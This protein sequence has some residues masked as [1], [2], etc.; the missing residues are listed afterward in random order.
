MQNDKQHKELKALI[1]LLDEPDAEVYEQISSKIHAYGTD[2]IPVLEES[3]E[4]SFDPLLQERIEEIIHLIQLDD[5]YAELYSWAQ[6]GNDDLMRGFMLAARYQYPDLD[7]E[8]IIKQVGQLVQ[9]V[10]LELNTNLTALEKIKVVNHILFDVHKFRGNKSNIKS[11]DNLYL[12]ILL[13]TKKGNPLSIGILY[14]VI[15]RSL[16]LPVYGVDLPNHFVLAYMDV[17]E[18]MNLA[19]NESDDHAIFYVNPFNRGMLFTHNEI[20]AYI[21]QMKLP[22]NDSYFQACD[23]LTIIRRLF[24]ELISLHQELGNKEKVEELRKLGSAI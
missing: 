3:W 6:F 19:S 7:A 5:L 17:G 13:E 14:I 2:A 21:K 4:Q 11:P 16:K 22:H 12:N 23:N 1:S 18:N 9:D 15:A 8:K 10:W 24:G 20:E